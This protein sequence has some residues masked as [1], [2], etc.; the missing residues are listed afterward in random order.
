MIIEKIHII[1]FGKLADFTLDLSEGINI[2]E[3]GN[4]SGKSTISAFIKFMFYGLSS[5][6]NE[7]AI[8]GERPAKWAT[9]CLS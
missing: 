6:A 3:G 4:E 2:I 1:S 7:R 5:D 9:N 8:R